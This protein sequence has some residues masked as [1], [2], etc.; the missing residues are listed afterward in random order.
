MAKNIEK[1][2]EE[3]VVP[4]MECAP[5]DTASRKK[6]GSTVTVDEIPEVV[7]PKTKTEVYLEAKGRLKQKTKAVSGSSAAK[8]GKRKTRKTAELEIAAVSETTDRVE[9]EQ[10]KLRRQILKN[11]DVEPIW[12]GSPEEIVPYAWRFPLMPDISRPSKLYR[13]TV[14]VFSNRR[15]LLPVPTNKK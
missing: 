14:D 15:W 13:Q 2:I 10:I 1:L 6:R 4:D 11:P 5:N 3:T 7:L 12:V 9:S 8:T